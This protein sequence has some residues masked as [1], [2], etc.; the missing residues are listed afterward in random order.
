MVNLKSGSAFR[1][2]LIEAPGDLILLKGATLIEPG[3]EPVEVSG[4]VIIEKSNVDFI[5]VLEN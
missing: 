2:F 1:G 3:A 5:Q 4:E